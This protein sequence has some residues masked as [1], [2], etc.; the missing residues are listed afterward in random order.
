MKIRN[1]IY[2]FILF[3]LAFFTNTITIKAEE[4]FIS[5]EL[6]YNYTTSQTIFKFYSSE[7]AEVKVLIDDFTTSEVNLV[8][9][10][11]AS[12]IWM[13]Y[14]SGNLLGKE[15]SYYVRLENGN[16]YSN[17]IDPYGK[18]INQTQTRNLIYDESSITVVDENEES[19]KQY[20]IIND[21]YKIIYGIN[22]ENFTSHETWGG[23]S[24]NKGKLLGLIET[25][26]KYSDVSTGYDYVSNIGVTYIELSKVYDEMLPFAISKK[27]VKDEYAYSGNI[28]MKH[29]SNKYYSKGIGVILT[30]N[31]K[32]LNGVFANN[33]SKIDK[34][35]YLTDDGKIDLSKTMTKEY[36]ISLLKYYT[37][38]Y[39][40]AGIMIEN[41][42]DYEI[43]F[44]NKISEEL[45]KI[46]ANMYIYG[47]G[48]YTE[49]NENTAGQNNLGKL[50]NVKMIN[51]SLNYGL[52]GNL[53]DNNTSGIL[54]GN[55]DSN[56]IET[57]KF[58]LLSTVDNGEIDYEK[59]Q[60]VSYKDYWN[61]SKSYQIINYY[62]SRNGLSV[63][64]KLFI[65]NFTSN[66]IIQQ[67]I[68][69]SFGALMMS[70]G[71]PYIYSG[72][73]FLSSYLDTTAQSTS[74]CSG[75]STSFCFYTEEK[76]KSIDW[77]YAKTNQNVV[78]SFKS[79]INFKKG[80]LL[81]AQTDATSIKNNVK[82]Y[83]IEDKVGLLGYVRN[84]PNVY[85]NYTEK[86]MVL[87]NFSNNDYEL[88]EKKEKG[89]QGIYNYN[90]SNRDGDVIK[91]KANS[92]YSERKIKQAKLNSWVALLI[93]LGMIGGLYFI[94]I[95]LNR[96]LV[97][98]KGYDITQIKRKYRP[99]IRKNKIE[100]VNN[101]ET[102][103]NQEEDNNTENKE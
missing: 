94:N 46:N 64:D 16:E 18:F 72:E 100:K 62:G 45:L 53:F 36:I 80:D 87:F 25:N 75:D 70:G 6:G 3:A 66:A 67:K 15:Y 44:I 7:A 79:Y 4:T 30:F 63:Y 28:E 68:I 92:F 50:N 95:T 101:D 1:Y 27:L 26:T 78:D 85:T 39:M 5:D 24:E 11:D 102:L 84:Y 91:L 32:D 2:A 20:L 74:L 33:I 12:N 22:V 83:T 13:G 42:A 41:M 98:K 35:S 9:K 47:D 93:V 55:Y 82:F 96:K 56:I 31:Y 97:E 90:S 52:F 65:K 38:E 29:V 48:S 76:N 23:T 61:N 69:L 14:A 73:E 8:K 58:A 60:G 51:G 37:K 81:L 59:V 54:D 43:D 17:I 89:I 99:F 88:N 77:S 71:T 34:S 21:R 49:K 10:N 40:L 86:V 57:L 19:Q 103:T